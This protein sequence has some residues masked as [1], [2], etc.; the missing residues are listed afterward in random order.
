M[1]AVAVPRYFDE[2]SIKAMIQT[3]HY[4]LLGVLLLLSGCIGT[5]LVDDQLPTMD[6]RLEITPSNAALQPGETVQF[7]A[8]YY[9]TFGEEVSGV[10]IIWISSAPEI[11]TVSADGLATAQQPGQAMITATG[12]GISSQPALLT[13]V[14]DPNQVA[15][16]VV[17]PASVTLVIG[18]EQAFSAS[19]L[20]L[21]GAAVEGAMISWMHSNPEVAT[22]SETGVLTALQAGT[23]NV[24]A[25]ADGI[26]SGPVMVMVRAPVTERRGS[27]MGAR[28]YTVEGTA[29]LRE[30]TDSGLE[31]VLGSDFSSS[32]GPNLGVFLSTANQVNSTSINLGAL[33]ANSGGQTYAVPDDVELDTFDFVLI[34]CIPFNITFGAA[35]LQ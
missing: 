34:H 13:V 8:D 3:L 16:V 27:F 11:V 22:L 23:T 31:L 10:Q 19:A 35:E 32:Q 2:A 15:T 17:T 26:A 12:E 18:E 33:Q 28:S 30:T 25:T 21:S 14:A 20:N 5:D 6:A 9:D 24:V 4:S 1:H 7:E 29:T